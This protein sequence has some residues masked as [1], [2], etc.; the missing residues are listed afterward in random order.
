M[1]LAFVFP[2]QGSQS[3]GMMKTYIDN[4]VVR[5]TIQEASDTLNTNF[6]KLIFGDEIEKLNLTVNTQPILLTCSV[7]IWRLYLEE[8]GFKPSVVAGHS[9]GEYSALTVAKVLKFSQALRLVKFRALSMQKAVPLGVGSMAAI[10]GMEGNAVT[11]LCKKISNSKKVVQPANFNSFDQTVISGYADLVDEVCKVAVSS[12]A[13]RAIKLSVSAPFHSQLMSSA[14]RDLAEKLKNEEIEEP[15]IP[16]INNVSAEELI[17]QSQIKSSLSIQ[18]MSPV[19]WFDIIKKIAEH[20]VDILVECGPGKVLTNLNKRILPDIKSC[21]FG[22]LSVL[23]EILAE[24]KKKF[25]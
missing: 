1:K 13:K 19:K 7:A 6:H 25:S 17:F 15:K 16:F 11:E 12:G 14:S 4:D 24:Q 5:Y 23:N 9:L 18:A 8:G 22:N 10:I 3:V 2:G 21:S 20:N